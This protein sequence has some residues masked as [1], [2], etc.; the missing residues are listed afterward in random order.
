MPERTTAP[1]I[2]L[3]EERQRMGPSAMR[4]AIPLMLVV[5]GGAAMIAAWQGQLAQAAPGLLF[6]ALVV[7]GVFT[8]VGMTTLVTR[9]TTA[10]AVVSYRPFKTLRLRPDE[11]GSVGLKSFG[12]FDGG[13]GYHVGFRSMALTAQ[14]G[15]GVLITRPDGY[16]ILVGTQRPDAL[17][18]ALLQLQ[19]QAGR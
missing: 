17:M 3:F 5:L 12:L 16:R 4:I 1:E 18:S 19:R 15:M 6:G 9:I 2:A 7:V 11:I 14:T 10:E 13:I 8:F